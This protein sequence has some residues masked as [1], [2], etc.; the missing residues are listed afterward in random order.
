MWAPLQ[1]TPLKPI[2]RYACIE[3]YAQGSFEGNE[4]ARAALVG[5]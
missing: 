5:V 3:G 4:D 2:G 1:L